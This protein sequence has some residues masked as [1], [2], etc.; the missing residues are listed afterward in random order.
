MCE[1]EGLTILRAH[2]KTG[3]SA[4]PATVSVVFTTDG[5]VDDEEDMR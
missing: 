5:E 3:L 4:G 2:I 1:R